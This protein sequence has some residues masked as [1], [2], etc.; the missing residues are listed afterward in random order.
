M[1][2]CFRAFVINMPTIAKITT[3]CYII[4]D[5][6]EVL[7]IMKKRGFGAGKYNGPGGKVKAG[8][9]PRQAA[10]RE[11][12]E[13]VGLEIADPK[14]LGFIEFVWPKGKED[15]NQRCHIYLTR[16]FSGA[17][18]ESEECR[19]QWFALD[20]IPYDQMWD[21]DQYWYPD[22]LAGREVKKRFYFDEAGKVLRFEGI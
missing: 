11:I 15:W 3:L 12:K 4:N 9:D 1:L 6:S 20:R 5:N 7:L 14:E 10:V 18:C 13:E 17:P 2:F 19:P 16:N 22:A 8:E 21:D